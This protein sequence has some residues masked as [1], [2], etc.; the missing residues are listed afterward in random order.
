MNNQSL[1]LSLSQQKY[2]RLLAQIEWDK[3]NIT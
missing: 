3:Q 2:S 1:S